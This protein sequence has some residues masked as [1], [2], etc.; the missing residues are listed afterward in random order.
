MFFSVC[1]LG[2]GMKKDVGFWDLFSA[3][4]TCLRACEIRF[5]KDLGIENSFA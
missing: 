4:Q 5:G 3:Y 1:V 2:L